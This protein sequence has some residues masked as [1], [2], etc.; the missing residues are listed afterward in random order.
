MKIFL[1]TA[2]LTFAILLILANK[3]LALNFSGTCTQ[4]CM[5]LPYGLAQRIQ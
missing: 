2:F 5:Q 4:I 1:E 3:S